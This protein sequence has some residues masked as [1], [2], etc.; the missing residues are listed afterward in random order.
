MTWGPDVLLFLD[1]VLCIVSWFLKKLKH[2]ILG[3]DY[4]KKKLGWSVYQ[5]ILYPGST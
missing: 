5:D 4:I 3:A 2:I 1:P